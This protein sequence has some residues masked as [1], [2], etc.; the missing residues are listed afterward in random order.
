MLIDNLNLKSVSHFDCL[1]RK[2][3]TFVLMLLSLIVLLPSVT[4]AD[5]LFNFQMKLAKKGNVEAQFKIGEMYETGFGVKKDI[6]EARSWITKAANQGHETANFKLLYW[7]V[8]KK[9]IYKTNKAGV[10]MIKAK[11]KEGNHQAEYYLGKMYANGVGMK[12]DTDK[13]FEWLN[14]AAL[15]GVLEAERE[16]V[17]VREALQKQVRK[18]ENLARK[19]AAQ[20]RQTEQKTKLK[21]KPKAKAKAKQEAQR[22]YKQEKKV[23]EKVRAAEINKKKQDE[24]ARENARDEQTKKSA[25]LAEQQVLANKKAEEQQRVAKKQALQKKKQEEKSS[26]T[27]FK[28]D[29]CSGKSARF[30]STCR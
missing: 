9:G 21:A 26:K 3:R 13:A 18:K 8:K 10:E 14:K 2:V 22:K 7:D 29:P 12:K 23:E 28:S 24:K 11:A 5:V 20:K 16:V 25:L 1:I 19:H 30:L 15:A 27:Q 6:A 4:Q 17:T